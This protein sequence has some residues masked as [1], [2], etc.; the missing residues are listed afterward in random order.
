M[1]QLSLRPYPCGCD[2]TQQK[3]VVCEELQAIRRRCVDAVIRI[4]W[5]AAMDAILDGYNHLV[6]QEGVTA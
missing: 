2:T 4:D 5:S 1:R 6:R 3:P